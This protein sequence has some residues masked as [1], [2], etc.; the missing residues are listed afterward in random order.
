MKKI[1]LFP[2][3]LGG[4][5]FSC[6]GN[7]RPHAFGPRDIVQVVTD[8]TTWELCQNEVKEVLWDTRYYPSFEHVFDIEWVSPDLFWEEKTDYW[9]RHNILFIVTPENREEMWNLFREKIQ[10]TTELESFQDVWASPQ[11]IIVLKSDTSSVAGLVE[12]NGEEIFQSFY[13][14]SS[15]RIE[16]MIYAGGYQENLSLATRAQFGFDVMMPYYYVVADSQGSVEKGHLISVQ[17]MR[18]G[19]DNAVSR[20]VSFFW[21]EDSSGEIPDA[22]TFKLFR[23]NI[24]E[25]F[26]EGDS[27]VVES[28]GEDD[29]G[30]F[31]SGLWQN[32]RK[33]IGG[34]FKSWILSEKGRIFVIDVHLFAPGNKKSFYLEEL[35]L[36]AKTFKTIS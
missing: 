9:R 26:F 16:Y 31:Y 6:S 7:Y 28:Y 33:S 32:S 14:A 8:S 15:E 20:Y 35:R 5:L 12:E 2:V 29:I 30:C 1:C 17:H 22:E 4:F 19:T 25:A 10:P 21:F 23:D 27:C 34:P 3:V 11:L 36:I 24:S 18:S 13:R